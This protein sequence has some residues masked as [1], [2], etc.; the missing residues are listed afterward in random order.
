V[1]N[2]VDPRHLGVASETEARHPVRPEAPPPG[3]GRT[4]LIALAVFLGAPFLI[5]LLFRLL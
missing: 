1:R 5:Y 2:V 3:F 4:Q